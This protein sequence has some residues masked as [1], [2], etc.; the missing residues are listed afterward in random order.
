M[1]KLF[2]VI[3]TDPDPC[4][5]YPKV[6]FA[7]TTP[8]AIVDSAGKYVRKPVG[9]KIWKMHKASKPAGPIAG[10]LLDQDISLTSNALADGETVVLV[11][12]LV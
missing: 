5:F 8:A 4:L 11:E 9:T 10:A 6:D 12:H 7:T 3:E 1:G 2:V